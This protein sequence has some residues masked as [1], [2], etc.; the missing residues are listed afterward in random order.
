MWDSERATCGVAGHHR[1]GQLQWEPHPPLPRDA[2]RLPQPFGDRALGVLSGRRRSAGVV[3]LAGVGTAVAA[4][5]GHL[6]GPQAP[7]VVG[8][9]VGVAVPAHPHVVVGLVDEEQRHLPRAL[10]TVELENRRSEER[11]GGKECVS[12]CR[13][14]WSAVYKKKK[15]KA[16]NK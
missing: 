6:A 4:Q 8:A 9:H 15:T 5:E 7:A 1:P 11:R 12:T 10:V 16:V 13:Y 14:R 2:R 3:G